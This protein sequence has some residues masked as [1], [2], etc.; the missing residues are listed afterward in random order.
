MSK[1]DDRMAI[2][3]LRIQLANL[4][5]RCQKRED[6]VVELFERIEPFFPVMSEEARKILED[7][8]KGVKP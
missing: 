4:E 6:K 5:K 8:A 3:Q 2:R 7:A 1:L